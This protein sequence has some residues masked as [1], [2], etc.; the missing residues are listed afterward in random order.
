M[1]NRDPDAEM[2][3]RSPQLPRALRCDTLR[4]GQT[5]TLTDRHT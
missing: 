1:N 4:S 3:A 5:P 2:T